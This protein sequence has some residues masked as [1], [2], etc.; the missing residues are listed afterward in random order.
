MTV[1]ARPAVVVFLCAIA[2]AGL[3]TLNARGAFAGSAH[4]PAHQTAAPLHSITVSGHGEVQVAPDMATITLG[5][6]SKASDA[7]SALSDNASKMS[8]VIAAVEAQGVS[9]D[10]VQTT[11][12]SIYYDSQKG[13]Y[14]ADNQITVKLDSPSKVGPVL[15]AA[16]A[17]GAN[18]SW[19][20]NF[21]IKN[22]SAARAQA[23][24]SAVADARSQA[25]SIASA[26]KVTIS[27]TVSASTT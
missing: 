19:G 27:D 6:E 12:L 10:H 14:I 16:V 13:V 18:N 24:Q 5:V 8:A 21:G 11:N 1:S 3:W 2:A 26:L 22:D 25:D 23:L 4:A 9:A 7:A 17:A 15:D 20:V